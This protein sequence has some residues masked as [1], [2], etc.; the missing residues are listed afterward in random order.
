[1]KNSNTCI[2]VEVFFK[3]HINAYSLNDIGQ[4]LMLIASFHIFLGGILSNPDACVI[5]AYSKLPIVSS[6]DLFSV[7]PVVLDT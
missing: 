4:I 7:I 1:M 2:N 6:M 3:E 5:Y